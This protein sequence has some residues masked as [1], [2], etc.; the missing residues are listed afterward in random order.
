LAHK[1]RDSLSLSAVGL[2]ELRHLLSAFVEQHDRMIVA[3]AGAGV[4]KD[5]E[6]R[7]LQL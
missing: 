5:R 2:G 7:G 4:L 1:S 6:E 3:L